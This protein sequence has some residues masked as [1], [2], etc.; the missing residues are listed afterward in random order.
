MERT[1]SKQS[2][3]PEIGYGLFASE[4]IR[5]GERFV[6]FRGDLISPGSGV[7]T[8]DRSTILFGDGMMLSCPDDDL[9]SFAN[10]CIDMPKAP[11]KLLKPLKSNAPFYRK[12]PNAQLN[13]QIV[14]DDTNHRAYLEASCDIKK[15]EECW[16][17]YG[18]LYWFGKEAVT[19]FLPEREIMK[20][21]F[22]ERIFAYAG[23]RA[24]IKEFY[25]DSTGI[26]IGTG[27]NSDY[28]VAIVFPD[29]KY[30]FMDIPNYKN[31][32]GYRSIDEV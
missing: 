32:F 16:T 21:G 6:E 14:L 8:N 28:C 15:D 22:P 7:K 12:Y 27:T 29:E 10:D 13:C 26:R 20:N 17:H 3:V 11:R 1:Y 23:F 9:A 2:S 4:D 19:G 25:P 24:Y 31:M 5:A 30:V 18:F